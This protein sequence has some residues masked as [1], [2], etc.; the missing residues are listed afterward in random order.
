MRQEGLRRIGFGA[1]LEHGEA[2]RQPTAA[3]RRERVDNPSASQGVPGSMVAQH[4]AVAVECADRLLEI[5]LDKAGLARGDRTPP[6]HG[7]AADDV[8]RAEME[9]D[10]QPVAQRRLGEARHPHKKIE[11]SR[12]RV[13]LGATIQS[14]R[15]GSRP[16]GNEPAILIAQRSPAAALWT[17]WFCECSPRTRTAIPLG[18]MTDAR[19]P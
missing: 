13:P 5:D 3:P 7:D 4:R 10:G 14:P 1:R 12:R 19:R 18:L 11:P 17:G 2:R 8:G 6:E 16:S 9:M 15:L